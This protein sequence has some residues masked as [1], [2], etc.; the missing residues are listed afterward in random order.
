MND[1]TYKQQLSEKNILLS[2]SRDIVLVGSR[3]ALL[4]LLLNTSKVFVPV[5]HCTITIFQR[6][7]GMLYNFFESPEHTISAPSIETGR[8][9]LLC[10]GNPVYFSD[11]VADRVGIPLMAEGAQFGLLWFFSDK[12]GVFTES[13]SVLLQ[14][15]AD[16]AAFKI[17]HDITADRL[18]TRIRDRDLLLSL[19]SD[20]SRIRAR[21]DLDVILRHRLKSILSHSDDITVGIFNEE[22][23]TFRVVAAHVGDR[24]L[25]HPDF[26]RVAFDEYTIYDGI[27]DVVLAADAPVFLLMEDIL[28]TSAG[29][30]GIS[31]IYKTGIRSITGIKLVYNTR[32]IGFVTILSEQ[33]QPFNDIDLNL[34][35]V[36]A[37]QLSIALA[38]IL[39]N[40]ELQDRED[41]KSTLL[42]LSSE[43]A[44]IRDKDDLCRIIT[45][46]LKD[47]FHFKG[48]AIGLIDESRRTH[49]AYI[50]DCEEDLK[51]AVN[52]AETVNAKFSVE[53]G[54]FN[55]I[56]ASD[57]PLMLRIAEMTIVPRYVEFWKALHAR[58][59][60]AIRLRV[61]E[62]DLGA[63][64]FT[65]EQLIGYNLRKSLLKGI[66]AQLA[67][68]IS[69]ISAHAKIQQHIVQINTYREQLEEEK[70]YLQQEASAAYNY[71][72]IIGSSASMRQVFQMLAQ[73]SSSESTVLILGETGTG[74]ELIARAIHNSSTRKDNL[75]VKLNCSAIPPNLIESELFGHE[76][77]SFTGAIERRIGKFELANKGT[78]FLDEIGEMPLEMQTKLLRAIQEREIERVGGKFT[79]HVDVRII[80]ATNR[81]LRQEVTEGRFRSDL[82]YRLNVF[83]IVLPALR[84]RK[85]DIPTLVSHF[86]DKMSKKTGKN[87][88]SISERAMKELLDYAWPG[89][90]RELEH[91]IERSLLMANGNMIREIPLW[92]NLYADARGD[93]TEVTRTLEEVERDYIIQVLN[94]CKGKVYGQGGAA[95]LLGMKRSTL[96]SRMKKLGIVKERATYT[97]I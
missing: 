6:E 64:Y 78:L 19:S 37:S 29:H 81:N 8:N 50:F 87:I 12:T 56:L 9:D 48:F 82:Y 79:M 95:E 84:D 91:L 27:H 39:A 22:H 17:M 21:K 11:G 62:N 53:D 36:V 54:L 45:G 41:E 15:I 76:K 40:E 70:M 16:I 86:I 28:H 71:D 55:Q 46:R 2:L 14:Q 72:D 3:G 33:L 1:K 10:T 4:D 63:L 66:C 34:L 20:I 67:V 92:G 75:M 80:A 31:F 18:Q 97:Y 24:R 26:A 42:S 13:V 52:F 7:S 25:K 35:R 90:V 59:I 93:Y 60:L 47:I 32:E 89:N 88:S 83:P 96:I 57:D 44:S 94:K 61:G 69:N 30:P 74:K 49:S 65:F 51:S 23:T 43:L 85:E 5:T 38:N 77:G 58:Y 73:V 68:A